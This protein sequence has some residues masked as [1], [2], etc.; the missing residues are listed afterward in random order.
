MNVLLVGL[1]SF[2]QHWYETLVRRHPRNRVIAVDADTARSAVVRRPGDRFFADFEKAVAA[3]RID[4][5]VNATPPGA[6]TALNRRAFDLG[7]PVLCEKPIAGTFRD[8]VAIVRAA[9]RGRHRFMIAEN[10]RRETC[11]RAARRLIEKG[12][13]GTVSA[14][15]CDV[16]RSFENDRQYFSAMRDPLLEDVLVH[17]A[18][19]VRFFARS[20]GRRVTAKSFSPPESSHRGNAACHL[21]LEMTSGVVASVAGSLSSCGLPTDWQGTWRIEGSR[22]VIRIEHL[23]VTLA[24][25]GKS[26]RAIS[27][28]GVSKH[29]P[30]EDFLAYVKSPAGAQTTGIDYLR[31]QAIIHAAQRSARLGRTIAV[32]TPEVSS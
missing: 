20:D 17:I 23:S 13:I 15:H 10:Y 11:M 16:F 1:G 9:A 14:M 32:E 24:L 31:T 22:G 26:P 4:V 12:A 28:H 21:L 18:D 5:M 7:L 6:H 27:A 8:A 2:G 19:L 25:L 29:G 3:E 30:F